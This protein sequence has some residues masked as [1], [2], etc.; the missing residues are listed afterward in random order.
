MHPNSDFCHSDT[1]AYTLIAT[2]HAVPDPGNRN[3]QPDFTAILLLLVRLAAQ[4]TDIVI[5]LN[6]PHVPGEYQKDDVD[7]AAGRQGPLVEAAAAIRQRI[8]ETFEIK[9]FGLF[10]TED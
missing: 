5:T 9:D 6:V 1:P 2:Q 8:L 3:P 7:F 10:V 4:K